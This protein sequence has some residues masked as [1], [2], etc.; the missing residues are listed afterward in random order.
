MPFNASGEPTTTGED[1]Q[2]LFEFEKS[3]PDQVGKE[4]DF[5]LDAQLY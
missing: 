4:H 5:D 2:D 3:N 1:L